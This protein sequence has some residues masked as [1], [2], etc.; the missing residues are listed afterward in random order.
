MFVI[1]FEFLVCDK[2]NKEVSNS[3]VRV[4]DESGEGSLVTDNIPKPGLESLKAKTPLSNVDP[5]AQKKLEQ[6]FNEASNTLSYNGMFFRI[7][8]C[9]KQ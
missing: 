8:E 2:E 3:E 7:S 9:I 4:N 6:A 5:N 1:I